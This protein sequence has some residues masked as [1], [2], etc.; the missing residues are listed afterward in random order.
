MLTFELSSDGQQLHLHG[1]PAGFRRLATILERLAA[2]DVS[3]H[4]HLMTAEWGGDGLSS[5][6]QGVKQGDQ[7]INEITIHCWV[8]KP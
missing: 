4:E 5:E 8:Q 3:E 1:D 6:V 7:L 2:N